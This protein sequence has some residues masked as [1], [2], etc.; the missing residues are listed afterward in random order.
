M[1]KLGFKANRLEKQTKAEAVVNQEEVARLA[2]ELYQKRGGEN[3]SDWQDW[4]EAEA[5]LKRR[6]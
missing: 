5:K 6:N 1:A 4:F 2:Y 3:G